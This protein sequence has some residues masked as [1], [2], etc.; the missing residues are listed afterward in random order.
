MKELK[1]TDRADWC[2]PSIALGRPE[3]ACAACQARAEIAQLKNA[4]KPLVRERNRVAKMGYS[5]HKLRRH[6][7]YDE[8]R[9][10]YLI[11]HCRFTKAELE[12][13]ALAAGEEHD[14]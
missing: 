11:R 9:D 4:L 13:A 3:M 7:T 10:K 12:A 1:C 14:D 2:G 8:L 6:A 5:L